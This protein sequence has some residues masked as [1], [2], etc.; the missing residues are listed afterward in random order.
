M[1]G[2]TEIPIL[3]NIPTK[4]IDSLHL[5]GEAPEILVKLPGLELTVMG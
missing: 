3:P 4:V 1:A 2:F 5:G